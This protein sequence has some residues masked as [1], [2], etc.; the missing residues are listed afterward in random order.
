MPCEFTRGFMSHTA[1][2]P[3]PF[4]K[5]NLVFVRFRWFFQ[6]NGSVFRRFLVQPSP[7]SPLIFPFLVVPIPEH[8]MH[9]APP[10]VF[11]S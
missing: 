10:P 5:P 9:G 1:S 7:S 4:P 3:P 8:M 6:D 11:L 2:P